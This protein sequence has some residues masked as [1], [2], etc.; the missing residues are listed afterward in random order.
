MVALQAVMAQLLEGDTIHHACGIT[1]FGAKTDPQAAQKA[2]QRQAQVAQRVMQWRWLF[3]DE[4]SMV[5]AKL[6]AEI[7]MK[8]RTIMSDVGTMK[9]GARG[10]TRAFGGI[11]VIFV[12]DFWQLDPP[13]G[14]FLGQIPTEFLKN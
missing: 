3:I 8:L 1:P 2:S 7:D 10:T 5:S 12:G 13:K 9:K 11:N 4:I 6:L 14:G